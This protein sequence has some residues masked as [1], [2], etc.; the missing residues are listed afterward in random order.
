[1]PSHKPVIIIGAGG[2]AKVL[3]EALRLSDV[4]I[5]GFMNEE[6]KTDY[7]DPER[8][9]KYLGNDASI[10]KYPATKYCLVNGVGSTKVSQERQEIFDRFK[11][12]GYE[13]QTVIHPATVIASDVQ[14]GEGSQIMAGVI[15]QL[16][17]RIG[18]NTIINTRTSLDHDCVIGPHVHIAPGCVLS[19]SVSC[20]EGTHMG[21]GATTIQ[22]IVI[23]R[24]VLVGAGSVIIKS[25]PDR[26]TVLGNPAR[27][28]GSITMVGK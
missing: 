22:D 6:A 16:G 1:M 3:I 24:R 28:C 11:A 25:I 9:L 20:G 12:L 21:T 5:L 2:H 26:S 7:P 15:L 14:L 18:I 23:G 8:P 17:C 4:P 27:A 10:E 13:F 19:G